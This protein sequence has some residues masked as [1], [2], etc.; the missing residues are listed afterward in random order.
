MVTRGHW[1]WWTAIAGIVFG[2]GVLGCGG[3]VTGGGGGSAGAGGGSAGAGGAS[4]GGACP[5]MQ[6]NG[7][8]PCATEGLLCTYGDLARTECRSRAE[9]INGK[10]QVI[11]AKCAVPADGVCTAMPSPDLQCPNEAEGAVCDYPDGTI[12]VCSSCSLGPC[13]APPPHF[14]CAPPP[15]G[16]PSIAPNAGTPCPTNGQKCTYGFPCGP[17]GVEAECKNG[18]WSWNMVVACPN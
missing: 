12:C 16:C 11:L 5:A 1:I 7:D 8:E 15:M 17:S 9:C 3:T 4:G 14:Y 13:G 10:F 6:P 2:A 18:F